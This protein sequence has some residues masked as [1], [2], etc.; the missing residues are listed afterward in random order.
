MVIQWDKLRPEDQRGVA[1]LWDKLR[2]ED[3]RQVEETAMMKYA[4]DLDL[5]G[6]TQALDQNSADLFAPGN[7]EEIKRLC[8]HLGYVTPQN[9]P[10][11]GQMFQD[12][13]H[14]PAELKLFRDDP[15]HILIMANKI[16]DAIVSIHTHAYKRQAKAYLRRMGTKSVRFMK[17]SSFD[18][19]FESFATRI[20]NQRPHNW[21]CLREQLFEVCHKGDR[22]DKVGNAA[23]PG[24]GTVKA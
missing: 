12:C 17:R 23:L 6:L 8:I 21:L 19:S 24:R 9:A 14:D 22:N 18:V 3:K 16:N 10:R 20:R 15:E 2:P 1:I 13:V 5:K 11:L 7:V 4:Y